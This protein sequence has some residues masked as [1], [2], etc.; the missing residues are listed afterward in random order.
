MRTTFLWVTCRASSSS[1]LKRRS[2]IAAAPGLG[3]H[4]GPDDFQ[5]DDNAE[6]G[7]PRLVDRAHAADAQKTN[8]VVARTE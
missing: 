1:C 7:V 6:L 2:S 5:R 4:F 3:R 8:D